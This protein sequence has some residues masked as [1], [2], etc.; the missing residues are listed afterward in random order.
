MAKGEGAE[1]GSAAGLLP[2]GILQAGE[3]PAQVKVRPGAP[4]GEGEGRL[5]WDGNSGDGMGSWGSPRTQAGMEAVCG[6]S[7]SSPGL[8]RQSHVVPSSV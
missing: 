5:P 1:S 2:A 4:R 3:R 7:F 8:R 6:A